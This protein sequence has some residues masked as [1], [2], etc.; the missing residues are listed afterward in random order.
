MN[1]GTAHAKVLHTAATPPGIP[2]LPFLLCC[3]FSRSILFFKCAGPTPRLDLLL[4]RDPATPTCSLPPLH[5]PGPLG[6]PPPAAAPEAH[7]D[8]PGL[9]ALPPPADILPHSSGATVSDLTGPEHQFQPQAWRPEVEPHLY[10]LDSWE[11]AP[12]GLQTDPGNQVCYVATP[13]QGALF[14]P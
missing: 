3:E 1:F 8:L 5:P 13:V 7:A 14:T 4:E 12:R 11:R 10:L 9:E 2:H 6:A